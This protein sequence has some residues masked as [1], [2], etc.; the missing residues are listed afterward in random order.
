[1]SP[2]TP[3]ATASSTRPAQRER[4]AR[5]MKSSSMR[6]IETPLLTQ[7]RAPAPGTP[8]A[9]VRQASYDL[10]VELA[11]RAD[12]YARHRLERPRNALSR[13]RISGSTLRQPLSARRPRIATH[14]PRW[15]SASVRRPGSS[16]TIQHEPLPTRLAD[17]VEG[18]DQERLHRGETH[19]RRTKIS[20]RRVDQRAVHRAG[21]A[22]P[23]GAVSV[24]LICQSAA[25]GPCSV[26]KRCVAS[27]R[28]CSRGLQ[29]RRST[30]A[31][32]SARTGRRAPRCLALAGRRAP[33]AAPR[34][35]AFH[36]PSA[37]GELDR[38]CAPLTWMRSG[39]RPM[40][41]CLLRHK[42]D[43]IDL[44]ECLFHRC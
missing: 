35:G 18:G 28:H 12:D 33:P 22:R 13:S 5:R 42:S 4:G 9:S 19:V 32:H 36:E 38:A 10:G 39:A 11:L 30:A 40:R 3:S 2:A 7:R 26:V 17:A 44:L 34:R 24:T 27:A 43:T 29:R 41:S 15:M 16:T 14:M 23:I 1:M 8:S 31:A 37:R 21:E 6:C 25:R 20:A